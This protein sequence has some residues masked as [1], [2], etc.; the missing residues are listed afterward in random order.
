MPFKLENREVVFSF[1]CSLCQYNIYEEKIC[2][3]TCKLYFLSFSDSKR[4]RE[5]V[6]EFINLYLEKEQKNGRAMQY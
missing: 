5:N 3:E 4:L 6:E 1:P 2:K